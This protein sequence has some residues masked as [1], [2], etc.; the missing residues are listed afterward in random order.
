MT[1]LFVSC[2]TDYTYPMKRLKRISF[3]ALF[4]LLV[5]TLSPSAAQAPQENA[6]TK[7]VAQIKSSATIPVETEKLLYGNVNSDVPRNINTLSQNVFMQV[8]GT[9]T[10]LLSGKNPLDPTGRCLGIDSST[11][12]L[13]YATEAST[14]AA[15]V[16]GGLIGG[17]FSIPISGGGYTT[18]MAHNFGVGQKAYAQE[19]PLTYDAEGLG[20]DRLQPLINIW[21]RFRD[22]A[23]LF[24]VLAFTIIGLAIMFRVKIDAR[25]VMSIQNQ[26]PKVV[27]A[28]IMVTFSYAI[29]GFLI[30]VM[31]VLMFLIIL[32]FDNIT[33][34]NINPDANIFSTVNKAFSP[35]YNVPGI[36]GLTSTISFGISK[37]MGVLAIDFLNSTISSFFEVFFGPLSALN[38]GC[39]AAKLAGTGG[40]SAIG[41][42]PKFGG[43]VQDLPG[44][45]FLFGSQGCD[46]V[47]S[48][49][50]SVVISLFTVVTF[51]VILVAILVSLFRVWFTLIKSFAY[52]LVDTIMGPLW[53]ACGVFPGSKLNF[54]SWIKHLAGHLS[55]FP[56]TFG[57][58]LLGKTI[59]DSL[60]GGAPL[61]S[62]PLVGDVIGGNTTVAAF[63]G[64][65]FIISTPSILDRVRKAIGAMDF[66]L[67]DIK[68]GFNA[69]RGV[70]S[71]GVNT[72]FGNYTHVGKDGKLA[73][74]DAPRRF[75][76]ALGLVK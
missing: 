40:L 76:H 41:Y 17:T 65:G 48:F 27:I 24:F 26:I 45:G 1:S 34:S 51:I 75:M 43:W 21:T 35:G 8:L 22:I 72:A 60:S 73:Q 68:R 53:I 49:F 38:L 42:I 74:A 56:M 9:T 4:L 64:F 23:Y 70:G 57:V 5:A 28:I 2:N 39:Q 47:E 30:D 71:V 18:Y 13:G 67:T 19:N 6:I 11:G 44:V 55:V 66:G 29:A 20:Y 15:T 69:G 59:I 14:N 25:T 16:M 63:I 61:F 10:C 3:I 12:K 54:S 62:P 58:I 37:A 7:P 32:A 46:F 31:Y 50:K 33:P 36:I 52:V